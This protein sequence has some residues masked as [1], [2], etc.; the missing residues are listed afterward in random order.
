MRLGTAWIYIEWWSQAEF[1]HV[2]INHS[3]LTFTH[4]D[5]YP[6]RSTKFSLA[7]VKSRRVSQA[8]SH[9]QRK[10]ESLDAF[11]HK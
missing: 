7:S 10:S 11:G 1:P 4:E 9:I 2:V 5:I 3:E 8:I 6:R